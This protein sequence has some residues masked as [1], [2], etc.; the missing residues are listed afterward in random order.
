MGLAL[1]GQLATWRLAVQLQWSAV[2]DPL[3]ELS[4]WVPRQDAQ[5]GLQRRSMG[6]F[7]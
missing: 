3:R 2:A 6:V 5:E 7:L 1:L 4:E